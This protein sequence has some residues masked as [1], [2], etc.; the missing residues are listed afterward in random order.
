MQLI[1]SDEMDELNI[2]N[3]HKF[4]DSLKELAAP[5][6]RALIRKSIFKLD[7][8][9]TLTLHELKSLHG[10]GPNSIKKISSLLQKNNI[11][12]KNNEE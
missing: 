9:S 11:S 1:N 12:F 2:Q 8:F 3:D 10:M 6:R 7:Q 5:A 4:D